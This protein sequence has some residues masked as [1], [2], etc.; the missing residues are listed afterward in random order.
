MFV[1]RVRSD[2]GSKFLCAR[3]GKQFNFCLV[4][5]VP[6]N[7]RGGLGS[8]GST[9]GIEPSPYKPVYA[10]VEYKLNMFHNNAQTAYEV[11]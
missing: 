9:L 4:S 8:V 2:G 5:S 7:G 1:A 10:F 6:Q 3:M 11:L